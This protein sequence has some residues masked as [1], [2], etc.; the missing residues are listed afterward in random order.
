MKD[1]LDIP[2]V[3][4]VIPVYNGN[5]YLQDAVNSVFAQTYPNI[6]IIIVDDGSTD[7]TWPLIEKLGN[8]VFGFHKENG[9]IASALIFGI[10][11]AK[12]NIIAWL[13]HDDVFLPT[14]IVKQVEFL[15]S[16]PEMIAC[17]TDFDIVD[18]NLLFISEF[19]CPAYL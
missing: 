18:E 4:V 9:G 16:N 13:S 5:N 14:K 3:S 19:H 11:K 12:G 6:E 1:I 2:L 15:N 8:K 10:R 17:Y 7:E